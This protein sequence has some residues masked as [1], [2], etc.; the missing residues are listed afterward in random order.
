MS[1]VLVTESH[2]GDIADAIRAKNGSADTYRPGDMAAAI[3]A[4][5]S[6]GGGGAPTFL[7]HSTPGDILANAYYSSFSAGGSTWGGLTV[8]GSPTINAAGIQTASG[9][10]FSYDLGEANHDVTIYAIARGYATGDLFVMGTSYSLSNNNAIAF[11]TRSPNW[12]AG[13]WGNDTSTGVN[14]NTA[15]AV[16]TLAIDAQAKRAYYYINGNIAA[17]PYKTFANSAQVVRFNGS[18]SHTD[19][20][21]RF[22]YL[23]AGVVDGCEDSE[24][25]LA[26]QA[27]MISFLSTGRILTAS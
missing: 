15:F 22:D 19:R 10:G 3:A 4:I 25:I 17:S 26:N 2:L 5:P 14:Y 12:Y 8:A 1:K 9:N 7:T 24:T 20:A 13:V 18:N 27:D 11:F 23:F 21:G 6:G 16:M